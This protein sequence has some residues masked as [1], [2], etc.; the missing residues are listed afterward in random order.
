VETLGFERVG[1]FDA[2]RDGRPFV[3]LVRP[4]QP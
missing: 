3:V 1:A 2:R 4:E